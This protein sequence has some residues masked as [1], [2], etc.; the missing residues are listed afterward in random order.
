MLGGS[1]ILFVLLAVWPDFVVSNISYVGYGHHILNGD[2]IQ[3]MGTA[4][5]IVKSNED[6]KE[7]KGPNSCN[8]AFDEKNGDITLNYN[9]VKETGCVVDLLTDS[10]DGQFEFNAT[11]DNGDKELKDCLKLSPNGTNSNMFPFAY[12]ID[13]DWFA[14]LSKGPPYND[15][16]NCVNKNL[17][18]DNY[19]KC[20]KRTGFEIGWG[21]NETKTKQVLASL[22]PIGDTTVVEGQHKTDSINKNNSQ[23]KI[24]IDQ[25]W[26]K[27]DLDKFIGAEQPCLSDE[28]V[29]KPKAWKIE[30]KTFLNEKYRY[31]FVFYLLPQKRISISRKWMVDF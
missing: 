28:G 2:I 11:V 18:V 24:T 23:L 16:I 15:N 21:K 14:T 5:R 17:C 27:I 19:A 9:K 7:Y 25:I 10:W 12:S 22:I 20:L 3:I 6:L 1:A 13:L 29:I 4:K 8:V 31:L 30:D 26:P